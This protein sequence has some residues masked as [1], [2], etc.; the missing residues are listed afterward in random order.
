[1]DGPRFDDLTRVL[2]AAGSRRAVLRAV[3]VAALSAVGLRRVEAANAQACLA[4]G[5]GCRP[6]DACCSGECHARKCRCR[7]NQQR[8]GDACFD[9]CP[10]GLVRDATCA[11][12]CP[13]DTVP[14]DG[15][16]RGLGTF[17]EDVLNCGACGNR[18]PAGPCHRATCSDGECG[19]EVDPALVGSPC[20]PDDPCVENAVCGAADGVC[21]GAPK[22]C[23]DCR[24]CQ[25]GQCFPRPD[26]SPCLGGAFRCCGGVCIEPCGPDQECCGGACYEPCPFAAS[27]GEDCACA[28]PPELPNVCNPGTFDAYC[29]DFQ[30]D[31]TNCGG[32]GNTCNQFATCLDA[33]CRCCATGG[34]YECGAFSI[35]GSDLCC[36]YPQSKAMCCNLSCDDP[37]LDCV[38]FCVDC[39]PSNPSCVAALCPSGYGPPQGSFAYVHPYP[40]GCAG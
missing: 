5:A 14:C 11:C 25:G 37:A 10:A 30:T 32:C 35:S 29:A 21:A 16:C 6:N 28:C 24:I 36:D 19:L 13:G 33:A 4:L 34:D 18:C 2:G 38:T 40:N 12:V 7:P 8:C 3:A 20:V 9:P 22:D 1:M 26:G 23:G 39:D 15:A 17:E 31:W 27:R